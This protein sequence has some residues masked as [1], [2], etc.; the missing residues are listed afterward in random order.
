MKVFYGNFPN[1]ALHSQFIVPLDVSLQRPLSAAY[2]VAGPATRSVSR[3][4][5]ICHVAEVNWIE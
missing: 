2:H 5:D 1:A 4:V 3:S